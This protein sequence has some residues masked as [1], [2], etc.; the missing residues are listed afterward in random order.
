MTPT[1]EAPPRDAIK[2]RIFSSHPW[3][4][5]C[6]FDAAVHE[7]AH[8]V[9]AL[10][11]GLPVYDAT[12]DRDGTAGRAGVLA[13][14][15]DNILAKPPPSPE[16]VA[17]VYRLAAPLVW[18]SLSADVAALNFVVM[19]VAG[20]QAELIAG[21]IRLPGELRIHDRDHLQA[22]AILAA[23]DQ[24]LAMTWAQR[25][26]RHLLTSEWADVESI[27][28]EL[29]ATGTWTNSGAWVRESR[30]PSTTGD[31]ENEK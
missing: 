6:A 17:D 1:I 12:I 25:M 24:R 7:A 20:R 10:A 14:I 29:R 4:P 30:T 31:F 8:A 27:A 3:P 5:T 22:R 13:P 23:T 21:G 15:A 11:L 16:A 2:R 28:A 26:A 19:L 9:A 18:P